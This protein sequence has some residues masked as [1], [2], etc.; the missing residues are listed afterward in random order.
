MVIKEAGAGIRFKLSLADQVGAA[1]HQNAIPVVNELIV[2]NRIGRDLQELKLEIRSEPPFILP[3]SWSIDELAEG[4]SIPVANPD[5]QLDAGYLNKLTEAVRGSLQLALHEG[6]T[7]IARESFEIRLLPPSQ[8]SGTDAAPEL[9][10][11]FVRPNDPAIDQMLRVAATKLE[12]AGRSTGLDGYVSASK[13]RVWEMS[14][15]I[16]AALV[17]A[18]IRYV[19]PPASFERS[20]QKVRGPSEILE[21][22]LGTCLD[23]SLFY[24]ACLEQ[25]GLQPLIVLTTGHAFVGLWLSPD[26]SSTSTIDNIQVLRNSRGLEE[27][28][29]VETTLL[30]DPSPIAFGVAVKEGAAHLDEDNSLIVAIDVAQARRRNIRP[31]DLGDRSFVPQ[32]SGVTESP[33]EIA[34]GEPPK[35]AEDVAASEQAEEAGDR[36]TTWKRKLLDLTLANKLLNFK[37]TKSSIELE[38][39]DL[40]LLE[41]RLTNGKKFKL[42]PRTDVLSGKDERSAEV[43]RARTHEDGRELFLQ[44][45]LERGEIYTAIV[46]PELNVRLTELFRTVRTSFEEGGANTL[47]L[48]LGFLKWQQKD[49]TRD[50]L[51][52][53]LLIPVALRRKSVMEGFSVV[54]HEDE[55]R[56]NPTLLEMLQ[57]DFRIDLSQLEKELPRNESGLDVA[58]IFRILRTHIRELKGWEVVERAV[59]GTFSFTKYLMWKDLE[60]RS[61]ALKR[62]PVVKHLI[63]TPTQS[64]DDGIVFPEPRELDREYSPEQIFAPLSADSSQLSAVLAAAKGKNFVL[65]GPPGTGKSQT[66]TNMIAQCLAEK[67]TV[68]FVA[69]K[70]AALE[71]VMRRLKEIGL[72]DHALEIHSAKAQKS[73]VLS[74]LRDAWHNRSPSSARNWTEATVELKELRN[75]L[76]LL[77]AALHEERP[78]GLTAYQAFSVIV[79]NRGRFQN[80]GFV[81]VA[82]FEPNRP[83]LQALKTFARDLERGAKA[84]ADFANHPLAEIKTTNWSP[85]WARQLAQTCEELARALPNFKNLVTTFSAHFG[86]DHFSD[87]QNT[88]LAFVRLEEL[89]A[90]EGIGKA[91]F[92]L[93]ADAQM[94]KQAVD[95]LLSAQE[96]RAK[97]QKRCSGTYRP[98]I[99]TVDLKEL[100][101]QWNEAN[102]AF[103]LFKYF[104][105][106]KVRRQLQ[107]HTDGKV[108]GDIRNDL[109]LLSQIE[110]LQREAS[111]LESL[112]PLFGERWNGIETEMSEV[113]NWVVLADDL[114]AQIKAIANGADERACENTVREFLDNRFSK[115]I[116]NP[117]SVVG[118]NSQTLRAAWGQ[119]EVLLPKMQQLTDHPFLLTGTHWLDEVLAVIARWKG[120]I[121]RANIWMNWKSVSS[122]AEMIGLVSVVDAVEN[123]SLDW[124]EIQQASETSYD[125]WWIDRV[126]TEDA[127]LCS[128]IAEQ[129][130][131]MIR[132]FQELDAQV[133]KLSQ[134]IL[135]SKI[136]ERLPDPNAFGTDPEWGT[137]AREISKK[138]RHLPLRQLFQRIPHALAQLA[139]C[140][141]MSPLS[142]SQYLAPDA[143]LF[144]VVIF[145]EASQIP[146]WEAVGAIARGRQTVIVGD[147]EQLPPT[148]FG[149]RK[150]DE[151]DEYAD[152]VDQESILDECLAATLP[153]RSLNWHYRSQFES[154]INFSNQQYYQGRLVTFPSSATEDKAVRYVH[155]PGGIYERGKGR[156]NREEARVVVAEIVR[157][158]TS[159][160]F[161]V[162]KRSL[163]V[164]TFNS[165]QQKLIEDLLDEARRS[166]P[167]LERFFSAEQWHEA[168]FIK[169]LE[170]VQGD[171][172]DTIIFS[173][174]VGP[175]GAGKVTGTIS[176]LNRQ[177]GHRR[178]NVAITRA[179]T[180]M[181]IYATLLPE[182]IDI[183]Q[184]NSR[185]VIDFKHFLEY[186]IRGAPALAEASAPTGR[187]TDSPFED[188]VLSA[189]QEKGWRL[190]PQVGV[191]GFR[192]DLG[193][194]HPDAPGRYLAG[195]ECDG[196]TYHRQATAR[197]RDRLRESIL[198]KLGWRIRRV[199][200]TEW[201][202]SAK[203]ACEKLHQRLTQDLAEDRALIADRRDQSPEF[204]VLEKLAT[205]A[206]EIPLGIDIAPSSD[207]RKE[208]LVVPIEVTLPEESPE[209]AARYARP[210]IPRKGPANEDR[211]RYELADLKNGFLA[212][213]AI[214]YELRYQPTL[215]AMVAVVIRTE[216]P[217]YLELLLTRIARAHGFGRMG[218]T[219]RETIIG[220]IDPIFPTS[221]RGDMTVIWPEGVVKESTPFR[222]GA[223]AV[224]DF[225]D[226]PDVEL[227]GLAREVSEQGMT[228]E[229]ILLR[230]IKDIGIAR[231]TEGIRGRLAEIV[232]RCGEG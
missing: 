116:V 180:E 228:S 144:D 196:A 124:S 13:S 19:V 7:E 83:H 201:W 204:H 230:M 54:L 4:K 138:A 11:A 41:D 153:Q 78:N 213:P 130:E 32:Q 26:L 75:K 149:E 214:F 186:A 45:C 60:E 66:I 190:H 175:D 164:V 181:L 115:G 229:Q 183:S 71:V 148:S 50:C 211:L 231:V 1:F 218:V 202:H 79:A 207:S 55:P 205:F 64:F 219:I 87:H 106:S 156:V 105:K 140:L 139:P 150:V 40:S 10:A 22:R 107:P 67:K 27:M 189:L 62:N 128:F 165:P 176:S 80:I 102:T 167:G 21:R 136:D 43:F 118:A 114:L 72:E 49:G 76:N 42:F 172:R 74:Q 101:R 185:G 206:V 85:V 208:K 173:V 109:F 146:V 210:V 160:D 70:T 14:E 34:I 227:I 223:S 3:T 39:S 151:D 100:T 108:P 68:L 232:G 47:F 9:L 125:R 23:T 147:P 96:S 93:G 24:A 221:G 194:V 122:Q 123:R 212:T 8:W 59:L 33:L 56:F 77:V 89:Q 69:Q 51:A 131:E 193:V 111:G 192:I 132:R 178:L 157:R 17:E 179:R 134:A 163:G 215:R 129:H 12:A 126:V 46:D 95:K 174:A 97:L 171:E 127:V 195:V 16:W 117:P 63:E 209:P 225:W 38:C 133:S 226:I 110:V 15:A 58:R 120:N 119:V 52:P 37:G 191:S 92:F 155:V 20:G 88:F 82:D 142:I 36:L 203:E 197:D 182:Q 220:V 5:V 184:S 61:D 29:F 25:A 169:N 94:V 30:T 222:Y 81:P 217:I 168:V 31:L 73:V 187:D 135:K 188:A 2:E 103:F 158:L 152:V 159:A 99:F 28:I 166:N 162:N 91:R 18:R 161:L 65:F 216:G 86:A 137:L 177:G 104:R 170:N 200:S 224:R 44:K 48:A 154:L 145:D 113:R 198:I 143:D 112:K 141:M 53:V 35:F 84:V 90:L 199:W 57:Q 6:E 98:S 121:G